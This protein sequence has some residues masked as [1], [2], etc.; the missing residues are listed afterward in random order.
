VNLAQKIAI[1]S[2]PRTRQSISVDDW[3][4]DGEIER[5]KR[6]RLRNGSDEEPRFCDCDELIINGKRMPCPPHHDCNYIKARSALVPEASRIATEK[7]GNPLRD[8]PLGYK[9]TAEF[10]RQMDRLSFNAGLLR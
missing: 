4:L 6:E 1:R 5:C 10:N 7:I 3:L 9:W 2:K 8:A